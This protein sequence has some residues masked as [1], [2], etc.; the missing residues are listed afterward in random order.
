MTLDQLL[1]LSKIAETGS[2]RAAAGALHRAQSAVSYAIKNLEDELG[3][4]LLCRDQYRPTLTPAGE[5]VLLKAQRVL[6]GTDEILELSRQLKM[7]DEPFVNLAISAIV[8]MGPVIPALKEVG[9]RKPHLILNLRI[10][11]LAAQIKVQDDQVDLAIS[12]L[13]P[14]KPGSEDLEKLALGHV[15]LLPVCA[16]GHKLALEDKRLM[17]TDL[18]MHTQVILPS[19]DAATKDVRAGVMEGAG[20]WSASDFSSKRHLLLGGLGWGL[21]PLSLVDEDLQTGR[22]IALDTEHYTDF[23]IPIYLMRKRKKFQGPCSE[24]M[25]S[26]LSAIDLN[27]KSWIGDREEG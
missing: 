16:P 25:W 4:E 11:V 15:R 26:I 18:R 13:L 17:E 5:A 10:E 7:G 22:L 8:P 14:N 23:S 1:V 12:E 9:Q 2:F 19:T 6:A 20:T 3:V 24:L 27:S 21:M